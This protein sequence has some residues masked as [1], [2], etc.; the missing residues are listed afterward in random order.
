M[1]VN[2]NRA[3]LEDLTKL[4]GIAEGIAEKIINYRNEHGIFRSWEDVKRIPGFGDSLVENLKNG[5]V[6]VV[7]EYIDIA[8]DL[9]K[10]LSD[11]YLTSFKLGLSLWENNLKMINQYIRQFVSMQKN[12]YTPLID[13]ANVRSGGSPFNNNLIEKM[14]SIQ[15]DYIEH[16]GNTSE[17]EVQRLDR[18]L[19]EN[20]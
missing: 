16:I 15:R 17:R 19:R 12:M 7:E 4:Q 5:G 9:T 10:Q 8:K 11:S 1:A 20:T 2:L 6:E 3:N 14:F 13:I 18:K